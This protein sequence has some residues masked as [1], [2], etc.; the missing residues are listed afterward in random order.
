MEPVR[1]DHLQEL[2]TRLQTQSRDR[3]LNDTA[4][5]LPSYIHQLPN[6]SEQGR[7]LSLDVGGSTLRVALIELRGKMTAHGEKSMVILSKDTCK[8][9]PEL[10]KL[11]GME[12][13]DWMA[14]R[15]LDIV[16]KVDNSS[17]TGPLPMGLAWSFPIKYVT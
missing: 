7:F 1:G 8:I 15:I 3:L 16:S 11:E 13:F 5:M 14:A 17:Y 4:C 9:T 6:G 2:V 10:K 12:F